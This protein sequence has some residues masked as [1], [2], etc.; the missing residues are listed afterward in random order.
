MNGGWGDSSMGKTL[1]K[2][3]ALSADP[4]T[5]E[6]HTIHVVAHMYIPALPWK[7]GWRLMSLVSWSTW[8]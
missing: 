1:C 8:G 3:E 2:H 7:K 6:S 5:L 4:G